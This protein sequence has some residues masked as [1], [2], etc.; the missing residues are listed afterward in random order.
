MPSSGTPRCS[1][2]PSPLAAIRGR[3][4]RVCREIDKATSDSDREKLDER[5]AKLAGGIAVIR[6][7]A[8]GSGDEIQEGGAR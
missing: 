2:P 6:F 4:Q 8:L 5:W 3:M 1:R 7:G